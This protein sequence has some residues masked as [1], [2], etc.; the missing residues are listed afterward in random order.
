MKS[1]EAAMSIFALWALIR[2]TTA[3]QPAAGV[4]MYENECYGSPIGGWYNVY[5]LNNGAIGNF[6]GGHFMNTVDD[7]GE[8]NCM[9]VV[10]D[11]EPNGCYSYIYTVGSGCTNI[12]TGF[13]PNE[14]VVWCLP[15]DQLFPT[16]RNDDCN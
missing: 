3:Q 8:G 14:L 9:Q 1:V 15:C 6:P 16:G 5:G 4:Q 13:E 10:F 11:N 12:N 2:A 7:C